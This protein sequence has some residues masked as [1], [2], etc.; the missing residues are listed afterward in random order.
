MEIRFARSEEAKAF[1]AKIRDALCEFGGYDPEPADH[2]IAAYWKDVCDI[3]V[4]DPLLYHEPP[5]Y[6]A[7]C[8]LHHPVLGD[9]DTWWYKNPALWPPPDK[10][11][12]Y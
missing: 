3:E 6:Y 9:G 8:I 11:L 2:L 7:M 5:Y 1:C 10:W 4:E 12:L